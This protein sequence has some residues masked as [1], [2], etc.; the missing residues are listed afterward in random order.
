MRKLFIIILISI[1]AITQCQETAFAD[2][3]EKVS[4]SGAD[5]FTIFSG[6]SPFRMSNS[7]LFSATMD[8]L[9][10]HRDSIN[11][12][13]TRI[14]ANAALILSNQVLISAAF[15]S[16]GVHLDTLQQLRVDVNAGGV[17]SDSAWRSIRADSIS[18][19][20]A[21]VWDVSP[22]SLLTFGDET[23]KLE[24]S[25]EGAEL[26]IE[27]TGSNMTVTD[28]QGTKGL[29]YADDYSANYTA[30]SLVDKEYTDTDGGRIKTMYAASIGRGLT[31]DSANFQTGATYQRL[32]FS[33]PDS[34]QLDSARA[35]FDDNDNTAD[36][37]YNIIFQEERISGSWTNVWDTPIIVT[38][39]A[40]ITTGIKTTTFTVGKI[41]PYSWIELIFEELTV[42]PTSFS[43]A[44]IGHYIQ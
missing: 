32:W 30:R 34:I 9:A 5:E 28:E 11:N 44:L 1:A 7:T 33:G 43:V 22:V 8:S 14:L 20:G 6:G 16:L 41:P 40:S 21:G 3:P 29:I 10:V 12:I 42:K 19:W 23:L 37:D 27:I 18:T 24:S 13:D 31:G 15:D 36:V 26:S 17:T 2:L 39:A 38:G 35:V 4:T 25:N